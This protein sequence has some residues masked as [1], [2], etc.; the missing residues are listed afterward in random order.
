MLR[1]LLL[2]I[3][4]LLGGLVGAEAQI[5]CLVPAAAPATPVVSSALEAS[6]ILKASP[7]CLLSAYVTIDSTGD[8]WLM[9][10][11]SAT[12]PADGTVTPQECVY[13][14]QAPGTLGLNWAPLP[15]EWFSVGVSAAWSSTGCFTKTGSAH[16]FFHALVQ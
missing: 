8:G 16:A 7:G 5:Q 2:S 6:H 3:A 11:N 1:K 12:V 14:T 4:I 13:V 10:F 15:P 9:I